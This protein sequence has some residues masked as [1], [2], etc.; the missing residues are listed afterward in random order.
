M[1][2]ANADNLK[3]GNDSFPRV[4]AIFSG[5]SLEWE[6]VAETSV[7]TYQ[8]NGSNDAYSVTG[9]DNTFES[10]E[11]IA[12]QGYL[13]IPSTYLGLPVTAIA[14]G[15]SLSEIPFYNESR[16]R[17]VT[18]PTSITSIGNQAFYLSSNITRM[19]LHNGITSIGY[20]AFGGLSKLSSI[21][22]PSGITEIRERTFF[23]CTS[24]STI[25]CL[26]TTAPTLEDT[27]AFGN[28]SATEFHV[29]TGA[30]GYSATYG[31]LDVVKDL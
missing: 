28:V 26:A 10:Q 15:N 16:I 9:V 1:I 2:L 3:I 20:N 8:I 17:G 14:D 6:R 11:T 31:G 30:T 12:L 23:N 21:S 22:L 4:Q 29:P 24:L 25:N 27:N 7:L 19:V 13:T 5:E 18:I